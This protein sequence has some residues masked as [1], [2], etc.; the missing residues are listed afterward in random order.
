M[1]AKRARIRRH[2]LHWS[3]C[4]AVMAAI[5]GFSSRTGDDLN[6]LLP[7]FHKLFPG[8][9][10]FDWGH[11]IAY[12]LLGASFLWAIGGERPTVR[13]KAASVLLSVL[14][15]L[16]D[17]FHQSFVPGRSPDLMDIR[18]DAVGAVLAVWV[19]S[20]PVFARYFQRIQVSI[21]SRG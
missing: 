11:F 15:G 17:E 1:A 7:F 16:T 14:Y 6:T 12:F 4:V 18:N 5:F 20:L 9:E 2:L 21:N 3:P 8:M 13:A 19:L 10:G